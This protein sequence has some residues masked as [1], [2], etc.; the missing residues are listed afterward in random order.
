MTRRTQHPK[1]AALPPL[2]TNSNELF[3]V[4][5]SVGPRKVVSNPKKEKKLSKKVSNLIQPLTSPHKSPHVHSILQGPQYPVIWNSI[6]TSPSMLSSKLV[7]SI[8]QGLEYHGIRIRTST[9]ALSM[10]SPKLVY[11]VSQGHQYPG[12]WISISNSTESV[13]MMKVCSDCNPSDGITKPTSLNQVQQ[14]LSYSFG[15]TND[16]RVL[17]LDAAMC[18][19]G[20]FYLP[21]GSGRDAKAKREEYCSLIIPQLM[22]N[23]LAHGAAGGD[24]NSIISML[25][26]VKNPQVKMSPSCRNLVQSFSWSDSYRK[27]HPK[28]AQFS[29]YQSA[30]GNGATRIDRSYHWGEFEAAECQYHSISFSDHLSLRVTYVLP[31]L[32]A[33]NLA[34][35]IKYLPRL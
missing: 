34:P 8:S 1:P 15:P 33:R 22:V 21:S 25:D 28:T 6:F 3:T 5:S 27:L 30:D 2:K 13:A 35:Q 9:S 26:S 20:N 10:S 18:T 12:I 11:L 19:W 14:I 24:F 17:I 23:R 4:A 31:N 16:G 32:L 29:R 7:Y